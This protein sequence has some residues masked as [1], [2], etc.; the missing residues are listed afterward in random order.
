MSEPNRLRPIQLHKF[1]FN[2]SIFDFQ[3]SITNSVIAKDQHKVIQLQWHN[4]P[5]LALQHFQPSNVIAF[6]T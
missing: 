3:K 2:A 6:I 4:V 5:Y 1:P